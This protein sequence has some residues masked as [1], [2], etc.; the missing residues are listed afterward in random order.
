MPK[1]MFDHSLTMLVS[2]VALIL[3]SLSFSGEYFT[4][5]MKLPPLALVA[6][7]LVTTGVGIWS[8]QLGGRA[9]W[10]LPLAYLLML[11]LGTVV[12][13]SSVVLIIAKASIL[14]SVFIVGMLIAGNVKLSTHVAAALVGMLAFSHGYAYGH[15]NLGLM[16]WQHGVSIYDWLLMMLPGLVAAILMSLFGE[17]TCSTLVKTH[18]KPIAYGIGGMMLFA[19]LMMVLLE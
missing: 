10:A 2:V 11:A 15:V 5:L 9:I 8:V 3:L 19:G 1:A 14:L 13:P 4:P 16:G 6:G 18:H 7:I 17:A 12:A